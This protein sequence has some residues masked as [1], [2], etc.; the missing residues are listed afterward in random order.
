M[1]DLIQIIDTLKKAQEV[2]KKLI[3]EF[4]EGGIFNPVAGP[5]LK[6]HIEKLEKF[7]NEAKYAKSVAQ[8]DEIFQK[9]FLPKK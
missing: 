5:L 3:K 6:D 7:I 1:S 9:H 8:M 4:T 2:H